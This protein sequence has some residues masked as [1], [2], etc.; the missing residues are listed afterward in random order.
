[1]GTTYK[2]RKAARDPSNIWNIIARGNAPYIQEMEGQNMAD[3][4]PQQ[5][6]YY[7][8]W[9]FSQQGGQ[10]APSFWGDYFTGRNIGA[11][12]SFAPAMQGAM[13]QIGG[14]LQGNAN[15]LTANRM[16]QGQYDLQEQ[17]LQNQY[18]LQNRYLDLMGKSMDSQN[19][20][21]DRWMTNRQQM[22]QG[23]L[24][25]YSGGMGQ[26][27]PTQPGESSL[28][29]GAAKAAGRGTF[30]T[31]TGPFSTTGNRLARNSLTATSPGATPGRGPAAIPSMA[32]QGG[33]APKPGAWA[34][35]GGGGGGGAPSG[36]NLPPVGANMGISGSQIWGPQ[37]EAAARAQLA[38]V[39]PQGVPW[40][41]ASAAGQQGPFQDLI[42][43][44]AANTLAGLNRK[45][46]KAQASNDMEVA[47]ASAQVR[48]ALS[49]ILNR[50]YFQNLDDAL[51]KSALQAKM[52][53]IGANNALARSQLQGRMGSMYADSFLA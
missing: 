15:R 52:E 5:R 53:A 49:D 2:Q 19:G 35:G 41:G 6:D 10:S 33:Q 12:N 48:N 16:A 26:S 24:G 22:G 4:R 21:Y 45:G 38:N 27:S 3:D 9:F 40:Q 37:Q 7:P 51:A 20:L 32:Y 31:L 11:M 46:N 36:P 17:A 39:S 44:I 13:G 30:N 42:S 34:G 25:L 8:F 28:A 18:D 50:F 29:S 43:S 14:V 47:Q 1:M 23:I